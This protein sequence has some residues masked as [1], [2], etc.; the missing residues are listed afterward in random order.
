MPR[1]V[2]QRTARAMTAGALGVFLATTGAVAQTPGGAPQ[3]VPVTVVTVSEQDVTLTATLP[4]RVVASAV[5]EV[6]PQVNGIIVER[7]FDEGADVNVGD[8]LY[9]IDSATY[10]AQLAAADAQVAQAEAQLRAADREAERARELAD[11]RVASSQSLDDAVA[12]RDT[13][14]AAV[15]VAKAGRIAAQINLER[16]TIRAPLS[17]VIG[18]SLTTQGSLVTDG[19]A[20][21][22]AIIRAI[23][24]VLVDVTQSAAEII[25][26]KRGRTSERLAGAAQTVSLTLADGETYEQ[27]GT[28]TA[29]EPYVNEQ[30]GVVT[31]RL[32]FPNPDRLLLPGMYVQVEMPQGVAHNVVL[33]P[34][35]GVTRDRRGRPVAMVA[36][37]DN[38]VE[39]RILTILEARGADWVVSDGLVSGDRVIVEGLQ[40]IRAGAPVA[41]E[42]RVAQA[43]V[44]GAPG[45]AAD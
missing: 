28:L 8:P 37:R 4:G 17:G 42:E 14:A 27:T 35:Q 43:S 6:R 19:Q 13:A 36:N 22:L 45:A 24:P 1:F 30:T 20:Q 41:P 38:I 26:W 40:K 31:L 15:E 18:R 39:E 23:D 44:A 3:A 29:A 10:E 9:R 21:A 25:A 32:A 11:R 7:L 16:T 34:Q 12:A 2:S 5:A 33:A